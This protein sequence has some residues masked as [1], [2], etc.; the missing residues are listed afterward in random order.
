MVKPLRYLNNGALLGH[1]RP[2]TEVPPDPVT[3]LYAADTEGDAEP[4][5]D[6]ADTVH[7]GSMQTNEISSS[8]FELWTEAEL[9]KR[10]GV[11][12][13]TVQGWRNR[14]AGGPKWAK[15]GGMVRYRPAA[16]AAWLDELENNSQPQ[17]AA[18]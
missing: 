13:R 17:K 4:E 14:N 18:G 2:E 3:Q 11:S 9:A 15:L 6:T 8:T 12:V 7:V 5:T 1:N 10:L 16:V